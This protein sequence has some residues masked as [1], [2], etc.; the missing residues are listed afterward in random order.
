M[1]ASRVQT[2]S[3]RGFM[4]LC[5]I[6]RKKST[7]LPFFER[8]SDSHRGDIV[9][10]QISPYSVHGEIHVIGR[11]VVRIIK[12]LAGCPKDETAPPGGSNLEMAMTRYS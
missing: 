2:T 11:A 10:L 5:S 6:G 7:M 8:G 3:F 4:S 9:N 12:A 1:K